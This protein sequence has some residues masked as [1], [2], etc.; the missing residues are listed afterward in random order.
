MFHLAFWD[1]GHELYRSTPQ[2]F[3]A[4]FLVGNVRD[5]AFLPPGQVS[6][7][8]PDTP[9]PDLCSL[10]SFCSL[11]GRVSAIYAARFFHLFS[12]GGQVEVACKLASLLSPEPGSTVF[13]IHIGSLHR[14]PA[15]SFTASFCHSRESWRELWEDKVFAGHSV[16]IDSTL[17]ASGSDEY[18]LTWSVVRL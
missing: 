16:K 6:T 11:R 15:N 7:K 3:P 4:T 13:G 12:E 1:F 10:T 2:T 17:S 5:P 9:C 8:A 14:P 18:L